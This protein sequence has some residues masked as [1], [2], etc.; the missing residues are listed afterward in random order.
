MQSGSRVGDVAER[1]GLSVRAIHYYDQ[2]GL[3]TPSVRTDGGHRIYSDH[4]VERL[5]AVALLRMAGQSTSEIGECL[6]VPDWNLSNI[7]QSQVA[8]LDRQLTAL[9]TLRYRLAE[10][11]GDGVPVWA[12][13]LGRCPACAVNSLRHTEGCG[14]VAVRRCR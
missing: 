4:D 6:A 1:T 12:G 5:C 9:G 11:A 13:V 7:I 14:V 3:V 8:R 10:V 2:I